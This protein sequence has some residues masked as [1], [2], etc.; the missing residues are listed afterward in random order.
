MTLNHVKALSKGICLLAILASVPSTVCALS[1]PQVIGNNMVLQQGQ[2]V[3]VWGWAVPGE[4]ITIEFAGQK[5]T[6]K[7]DAA[8]RWEVRLGKL[9]ASAAPATMT[10]SGAQ[11]VTLTNILVG[12]VWLCSGQS[13][14]EKP[15]GLQQGQKPVPNYQQELATGDSYPNIRLFKAAKTLAPEPARDV[16]AEGWSVCSSNALDSMK[17]SAAAYFFAREIQKQLNV[18]VGLV[19]SSWGGTRVEPW[20]P[21]AG[22]AQVPAVAEL[23]KFSAGTNKPDNK[24]MSAIYNGMVA[25]LKPFAIRGA[26]WYQGESNCMDVNDGPAYADKFEAL[27]K[28]WRKVWGQGDFAFYYVQLAPYNYFSNRDKPRVNSPEELPLI[29]EAQARCLRLPNTGM[30]VITDTVDNLKD[31]HPTNK[32]D[33]GKRLA[34]LALNKTYGKKEIVCSGPMFKAM[35]VKGSE[36]ILSFDSGGIDLHCRDSQELNS[37]T[38]AG[39]DGKFV[40]AIARIEGETVVVSSEQVTEPKAVRFGWHE[41]AQPNFFNEAGLP[42]SPFR[43]DDAWSKKGGK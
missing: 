21:P 37:F 28:G 4:K 34:L 35:K 14:M 17:F 13:N 3:P 18:P 36:A 9:V 25:P 30:A 32:Q 39:A 38:I 8:G 12:E 41:L 33:V 10:V 29:W 42:A 24:T 16:K 5:K 31:I 1:L 19:E 40:P 11:T 26:L 43:T 6:A 7:A 20:T 2:P 15:I 22:L 23:A 27:I